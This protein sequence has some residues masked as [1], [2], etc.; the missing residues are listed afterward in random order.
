MDL[1]LVLGPIMLSVVA[2]AMLY[3]TCTIQ[4]YNYFTS[5]YKDPWYIRSL[6]IW[7]TVL[8]TVHTGSS[9]YLLWA[10]TVDNFGNYDIFSSVPWPYPTTAITIVLC[11]VPIQHFLAWRI[12]GLSRSWALFCVVSALSLAQG[13]CGFAGGVLAN[14]I[15]NPVDFV[16][17]GGVADAWLSI[18]VF[19]DI[20]ITLLLLYYLQRSKTGFKKTDSII[21]SLIRTAIETAAI[22]AI[23]CVVD[24]VVFTARSDTNLHFFFAL[25]Q[26]GIYTNTLMMTLNSRLSLRNEMN[27][28]DPQ[29]F[30][31]TTASRFK[32]TEVSIAVSQDVR[33][34]IVGSNAQDPDSIY[35]DEHKAGD[36]A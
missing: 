26:P 22:G 2:N 29:S 10:F 5:R 34:D 13:A 19:T 4:W 23:F 16:R 18:A 35:D 21:S 36:V 31:I 27:S 32:P 33:M 6:V 14:I 7:V 9:L 20:L 25:P 11:S 17:L 28:G 15:S 1:S 12:R 3:G 30:N 24:L 8:Y